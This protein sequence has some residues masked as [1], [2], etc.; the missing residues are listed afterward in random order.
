MGFDRATVA[1]VVRRARIPR[2]SFYQ[3]FSDMNDLYEF[4]LGLIGEAKLTY[5][6]DTMR[7]A[8]H[9]PALDYYRAMYQGGLAFGQA[10]PEFLA[11][12]RHLHASKNT[13]LAQLTTRSLAEWNR[14]LVGLIQRDQAQGLIRPEV[15]PRLLARL[16]AAVSNELVVAALFGE[17]RSIDEVRAAVDHLVDIIKYGAMQG[18]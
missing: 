16:L 4:V 6:A 5:L 3:Y 18:R 2:G 12:G 8:E 13:R 7:L 11:I 10:H 14:L 9:T 1:G 17:G 15:D